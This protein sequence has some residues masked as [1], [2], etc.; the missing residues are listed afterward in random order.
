MARLRV[1]R[2][3]FFHS[4]VEAENGEPLEHERRSAKAAIWLTPRTVKGFDAADF[5]ELST[6][7]RRKLQDAIRAFLAVANEVAP[8]DSPTLEQLNEAAGAFSKI[9]EILRPYV[10]APQEGQLIEDVLK[11]LELPPWIV[12][13][14]Y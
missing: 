2:N 4:R 10:S 6:D 11:G 3:L 12:N 7:Q 1:A 13:W 14:D 8:N 9:L 5:P